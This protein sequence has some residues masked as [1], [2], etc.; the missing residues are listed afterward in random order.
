MAFPRKYHNATILPDGTVLV[1]GGT[2]SADFNVANGAVLAA[3]LWN[4]ITGTWTT[5]ADMQVDRIY[6]S[7]AL[8]LPDGHVL[9]TG[10]GQ[11]SPSGRADNR[12][13]QLFSPP[14]LFK[15][16]RPTITCVPSQVSYDK[17]FLIQTSDTISR[18]TLIRLSSVT[19]GFN[20]NQRFISL[21]FIQTVGGLTAFIPSNPNLVP[22]GHYMLFVL[23]ESGVPSVSRIIQVGSTHQYVCPLYLPLISK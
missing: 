23:N 16:T 10:G 2:S 8:L 14:Y 11:P 21:N 1:T 7:T 12:D 18:V 13:A 19:H 20:Q 17:P 3:E 4:P 6:H 22:P 15:G 9:V 5:L